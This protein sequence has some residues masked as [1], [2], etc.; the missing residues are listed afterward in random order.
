[1]VTPEEASRDHLHVQP[2]ATV[3]LLVPPLIFLPVFGPR[4]L[5]AAVSKTQLKLSVGMPRMGAVTVLCLW[6]ECP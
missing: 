2:Q 4:I 1:M 5:S 3:P 6:P